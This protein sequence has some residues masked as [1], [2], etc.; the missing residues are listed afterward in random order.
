MNFEEQ[1]NFIFVILI[2]NIV[3]KSTAIPAPHAG[4]DNFTCFM[5]AGFGIFAV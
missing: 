2:R 3:R 1:N 5:S 4:F